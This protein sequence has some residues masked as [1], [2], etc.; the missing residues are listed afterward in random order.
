[1][2]NLNQIFFKHDLKPCSKWLGADFFMSFSWTSVQSL[3]LNKN[4]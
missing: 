1:M 4:C 3:V 2:I